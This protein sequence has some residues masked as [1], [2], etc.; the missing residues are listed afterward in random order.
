MTGGN[1][2]LQSVGAERAS[3]RLGTRQRCETA[4][5]EEPVP[6]RAVLL[7]KRDGLS[8]WADP[9][10]QSRGLDLHQGDQAVSLLLLRNEL[11]EDAAETQR[12][13]AQRGPHPVLAGSCR[14]AFVENE[15]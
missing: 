6:A 1:R 10:P 15:V 5:D 12:F 11:G 4:T 3:E 13:L 8:S 9:R 7:E 2:G 14:I